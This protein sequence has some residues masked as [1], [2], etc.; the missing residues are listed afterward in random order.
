MAV[1]IDT[2]F[3]LAAMYARDKNHDKART[4]QHALLG[5]DR[6]IA[7][8]VL[9]ELFYMSSI[10]TDYQRAIREFERLQSAV[11]EIMTLTASDRQ[12]MTEIM[13][14]YESAAFDYTDTAIMAVSERLNIEPVYTFD[15][16]DF[17]IFR[18][19][20]CEYLELRP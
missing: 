13:R 7:E 10:R 9:Q 5:H 1:L 8:P 20:H 12:R 17:Q 18:P 11:F 2:S 14:Q 3:L 15:H 6:I 19:R 4:A 16:R